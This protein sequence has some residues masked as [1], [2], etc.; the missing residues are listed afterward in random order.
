MSRE[1]K[2][3]MNKIIEKFGGSYVRENQRTYWVSPK[4]EKYHVNTV[5][6]RRMASKQK[7]QVNNEIQQQQEVLVNGAVESRSE[8]RSEEVAEIIAK[9]EEERIVG[10]TP[11][12]K[13]K[14]RKKKT[15]S[16]VENETQQGQEI[17]I[18]EQG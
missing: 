11:K 5:F 15:E 6:L 17:Q 8:P 12:K 13:K 1:I 4:N 9:V 3:L 7:E 16:K 14:D 18:E 10:E 2:F